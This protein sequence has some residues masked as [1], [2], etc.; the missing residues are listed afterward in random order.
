VSKKP[1]AKDIRLLTLYGIT[2]AEKTLILDR[3]G[4]KCA[5][6]GL[7]PE[8]MTLNADHDHRTGYLRGFLCL[9]CN[10]GL[11]LFLD[12]PAFLRAAADYLYSYPA[13]AALGGSPPAGRVGRATRKWRTKREMRERLTWV[14]ERLE[15]LG[16]AAPKRLRKKAGYSS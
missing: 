15:T 2:V 10:K 8:K 3:Q 5:I 14:V 6:C 7:K 11:S 1:T 16:Y 12:N 13:A 9:R 4:D